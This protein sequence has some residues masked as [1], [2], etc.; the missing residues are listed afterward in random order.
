MKITAL[1]KN[2]R[3]I[4]LVSAALKASDQI[5]L[6]VATRVYL[7]NQRNAIANTKTR[8]KISG[9]GKKPWKQK[10]T[11]RARVGDNRSPLWRGGGT[12]FGPTNN[13]N[14]KSHLNQK[15]K[16]HLLKIALGTKSDHILSIDQWIET[17][18]TKDLFQAL[19]SHSGRLMLVTGQSVK[20]L[21]A[22]S[23][24]LPNV[25]IVLASNLNALDVLQADQLIADTDALDILEARVGSK[26]KKQDETSTDQ[27]N[28]NE[29][30]ATKPKKSSATEK[31]K[32]S[33]T[34]KQED[35][36]IKKTK[37]S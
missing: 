8:G 4:K 13:R 15:T 7:G 17:S 29:A 14:F 36:E 21:Q 11:G 2:H 32:S 26:K 22:A 33:K 19:E 35:K 30:I 23:N 37:Q 16:S 28:Q 6:A 9:G 20:N 5:K 12:I 25:K 18:K 1:P 10:G 31:A 34:K 3:L 24:N 27:V